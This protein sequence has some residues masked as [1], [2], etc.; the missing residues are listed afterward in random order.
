MAKVSARG[1]RE[2]AH[3][4]ATYAPEVGPNDTTT[5][6]HYYVFRSDGVVLTRLGWK[7]SGTYSN[8][9]VSSGF[10]VFARYAPNNLGKAI[11]SVVGR[12]CKRADSVQVGIR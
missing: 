1:C 7:Y 10:S 12:L 9:S 6:S 2:L 3:V 11:V 8:R 4:K 5:T